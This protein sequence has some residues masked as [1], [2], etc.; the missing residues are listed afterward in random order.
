M[1]FVGGFNR[2]ELFSPMIS[3]TFV[4]FFKINFLADILLLG[5]GS[6]P[7]LICRFPRLIPVPMVGFKELL[8]RLKIQEQMNKQHQTRLDVSHTLQRSHTVV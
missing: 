5:V 2:F 8:R 6:G 1:V 3:D 4:A 7:A